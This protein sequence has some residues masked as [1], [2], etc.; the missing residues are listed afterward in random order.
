[1]KI[2]FRNE[3][4][5]PKIPLGTESMIVYVTISRIWIDKFLSSTK[6][7]YTRWTTSKGWDASKK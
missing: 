5:N 1:M 2:I 6:L 7:E 3:F 4:T